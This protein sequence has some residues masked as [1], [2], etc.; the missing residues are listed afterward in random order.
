MLTE[1]SDL[2]KNKITTKPC[3]IEL[4]RVELEIGF[5]VIWL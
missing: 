5:Y 1:K 4:F 2:R 3:N